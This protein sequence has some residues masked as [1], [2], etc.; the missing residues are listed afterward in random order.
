MEKANFEEVSSEKKDRMVYLEGREDLFE[1]KLFSVR[2]ATQEQNSKEFEKRVFVISRDPGSANAL[3]PVMAILNEK[4]KLSLTVMTDG[5]AQEI[6]QNQFRLD[7]VT[8]KDMALGAD[9]VVGSPDA[10]LL[11]PSQSE[12]GVDLY[13]AA[14]YREVP[15]VIVEDYYTSSRRYLE[16]LKERHLPNPTKICVIDDFAKTLIIRDFPELEDNIMVTGQPAFDRFS[17][18]NTELIGA[19]TRKEL[20][21]DQKEKFVVFF[22]GRQN[23]DAVKY[24]IKELE[25]A[26]FKF[27]FA[28]RLHPRDNT[29]PEEYEKIFSQSNIDVIQ[30]H[31]IN[32]DRISA[33][34][35]VVMTVSSTEGIHAIYRRK[36]TIHISD[37]KFAQLRKDL[38]PAPPV[39]L[40]ASVGVENL[41]DLASNIENLLNPE[42]EVNV[43]LLEHMK[44]YYKSDGKN[45]ERV[46]DIVAEI[47]SKKEE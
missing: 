41:S 40:G 7:D 35:D 8:P 13:T 47:V 27:K 11:D 31:H 21:I 14:T 39:Q 12:Q 5:R 25:K 15:T 42:S 30:T 20:N 16:A 22:S 18:E 46:A 23:L 9:R 6:F 1:T 37:P 43:A 45:A 29:P 3:A 34:D 26:S 10:I 2:N 44:K 33:A 24:F 36:P 28:Y 32:S 4:Q 17:T 19:E 38:V